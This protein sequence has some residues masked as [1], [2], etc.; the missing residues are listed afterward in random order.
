MSINIK[1]SELQVRWLLCLHEAANYGSISKAAEKNG[2]KQSN[3]SVNIKML[4][5]TF[6]EQLVT[7]VHNGI[8]LTEA[9]KMVYNLS[10][11]LTN[12]L[13]N[14]TNA[15]VKSCVE[16]G[17]IRVWTSDG[18]GTGYIS[19]SFN[20]FYLDYPNVNIEVICSLEM[21]QLDQFDMA[22]VYEKPDS[23]QLKSVGEYTLQ[24]GLFASKKYLQAYGYPKSLDE[25]MLKHRI[26][27][28]T[29]FPQVWKKWKEII[30]NAKIVA[31]KTNSSPMLLQIIKD[32]IGIGLLPISTASR[33]QDLIHLSKI[34]VHF[35]HKFWIVVRKDIKDISKIKALLSF[36]ENASA[37]L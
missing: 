3:F 7:R 14:I 32:G 25:I 19:K 20:Y 13:N 26:C 21:P 9:G 5:Q 10:C 34:K 16:S 30:E 12:V 1:R 4:E 2:M 6:N 31:T 18:L 8:R 27:T 37:Q 15:K 17:A 29:N 23:A 36:I 28:R 33:E 22:I 11:D 35:E 24:F